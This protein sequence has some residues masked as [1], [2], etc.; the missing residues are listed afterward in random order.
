MDMRL[1]ESIKR[2]GEA[3]AVADVYTGDDFRSLMAIAADLHLAA[4]MVVSDF[5]DLN[6]PRGSGRE[7]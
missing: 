3:V 5:E 4:G 2:L 6:A 7:Y 1:K